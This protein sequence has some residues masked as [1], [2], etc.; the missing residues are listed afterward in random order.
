MSANAVRGE[1]GLSVCGV[2]VRLRPSFAALV[3]AEDELGLV[4][5]CSV[6]RA[7]EGLARNWRAGGLVMALLRRRAGGASRPGAV[8]RG[9]GG[10]GAGAV[11]AG[12]AGVARADFA[13]AVRVAERLPQQR[14]AAGRDRRG[15]LFGWRPAEFWEAT[16]FGAGGGGRRRCRARRSTTARRRGP[17]D[18]GAAD[19]G[20]SRWMKRSRRLVVSVRADTQGARTAMSPR[21]GAELS[22]R[23]WAARSDIA[24]RRIEIEALS[25]RGAHR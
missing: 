14:G 1:A 20:V 24:G 13:G 2:E 11:D 15:S 8:R 17:S 23:G 18:R 3:A 5:R 21:C 12:A 19:G 16:P 10:A 6:E 4:V 25:A 22:R 7:A 9:A